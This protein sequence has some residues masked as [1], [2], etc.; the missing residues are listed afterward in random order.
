MTI[1]QS[2]YIDIK[3][4]VEP[5]N[6]V[7]R[8]EL[9]GRFFTS[10]ESLSVNE[11]AEF[12]NASEVLE[13][14][15][16]NSNEYKIA[17]KYFSFVS[18]TGITPYK[19]SFASFHK[20]NRAGFI[21]GAVVTPL[22]DLK[23]ITAGSMKLTIDGM[24]ATVSNIN[25]SEVE[26]Y[27]GVAAALQTA[28][29][30]VEG[31]NSVKVEFVTTKG[32]KLTGGTVGESVIDYAEDV[33]EGSIA[34]LI[35]WTLGTQPQLSNGANQE[36]AIEGMK[37][38]LDINNNCGS[39]TFID[40]LTTNEI[41]EIAEYNHSLNTQYLYSIAVNSINYVEIQK[42]VADYDGV[43]LTFNDNDNEFVA[44]MVMAIMAATNY[45]TSK[46]TVNY[47]FAQFSTEKATVTTDARA[48]ELDKLRINYYG[49]TQSG[50]RP[51]SF[52]QRGYLQGS[53]TD[54]AVYSNEIWLKNALSSLALSTFLDRNQIAANKAGIG[55][56][57]AALQSVI[58][59]AVNNGTI[60]AEKELTNAQRAVIT[61][62]TGD[63]DAWRQVQQAGYWIT[64]DIVQIDV[65]GLTEY[66]LV[67]SLIYSKGDSIRKITGLDV[68][69]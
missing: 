59:E 50:G 22:A 65:N 37:R 60:L 64:L 47:M 36:T 7:N 38:I 45:D 29:N 3:T 62:L 44:F 24:T 43:A 26:N 58:E 55:I 42:A 46:G 31:W 9:I 14:F 32:F 53:I 4:Q 61:Q 8:K 16:S 69:I 6:K 63:T 11:V 41:K 57:R 49:Q 1:S 52:F 19:I 18:K 25:L 5:K 34:R 21:K 33:N 68:L 20:N 39:F 15:G 67:Y 40:Q 12:S 35:G 28:I 2:R 23:K 51:V 30:A 10:S 56:M 48:N 66:H 13:R 17:N 27:A 54:I